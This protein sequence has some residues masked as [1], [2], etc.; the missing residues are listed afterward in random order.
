MVP[1]NKNINTRTVVPGAFSKGVG[2]GGLLHLHE[3]D[4]VNGNGN[5]NGSS[6]GIGFRPDELV[7]IQGRDFVLIG[8]RLRVLHS[9]SA[10]V[11]IATDIVEFILEAHAVVRARVITQ[12]GEFTGT[13]VATAA[14]DPK[15]ADALIELAE[16]RAIARALR[17]AGIGVECCGFEELA[18]GL[19]LEGDLPRQ[20][21]RSVPA[22]SNGGGRGNGN[23]SHH[24]T[25]ATTAQRRALAAIAQRLGKDL[26]AVVAQ[27]YPD[28]ES[29]DLSLSQ[30]SKLIDRLK[31]TNGT[32]VGQQGR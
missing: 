31:G 16:T 28:Q 30:A 27:A 1:A 12:V 8:G 13:G 19:A 15:L 5:G 9:A 6:G 20:D 26:D 25:P 24:P 18:A 3:E 11:S 2:A 14:R 4:N 22:R 32:H 7:K 10:K 23:G 29:N 17:F 21:L